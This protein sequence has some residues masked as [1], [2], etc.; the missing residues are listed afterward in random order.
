MKKLALCLL[1][2]GNIAFADTVINQQYVTA[3]STN[4]PQTQV[5][6]NT[7]PNTNSM[8][9]AQAAQQQPSYQTPQTANNPTDIYNSPSQTQQGYQ[10]QDQNNSQYAAE[11]Q[12]CQNQGYGQTQ[13]APLPQSQPQNQPQYQQPM[14]QPMTQGSQWQ[15][16]PQFGTQDQSQSWQTQSSYQQPAPQASNYQQPYQAPSYQNS[17]PTQAQ[18]YQPMQQQQPY[19]QQPAVNYQQPMPVA[20]NAPAPMDTQSNAQ[21][22]NASSPVNLASDPEAQQ[23]WY[24]NCLK[25][26]TSQS[27]T[28]YANAFCQCGWQKISTSGLDPNLFTSQNPADIQKAN[29][30]LQGISQECLMTV[31]QQ[32]QGQTQAQG[33]S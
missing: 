20:N 12:A 21:M 16:R 9:Q 31:M 18:G 22:P 29:M 11:T 7:S 17:Y 25:A 23:T 26:V 24:T 2:L 32:Q 14:Q 33:T 15:T 1:M 28:P 4:Q 27:M 30:V 5:A 10:T 3:D 19:Q 6:P 13:Y 8:Q